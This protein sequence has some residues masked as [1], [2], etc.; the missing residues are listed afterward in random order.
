MNLAPFEIPETGDIHMAL[1]E[2]LATD[3][4]TAKTI[5]YLLIW[6]MQ[7]ALT[8][9]QARQII[10]CHRVAE[11][12]F[13]P[14]GAAKGAEW[15]WLTQDRP[16]TEDSAMGVIA[17]FLPFVHPDS[18]PEFFKFLDIPGT[19]VRAKTEAMTATPENFEEKIVAIEK[20]LRPLV[21]ILKAQGH[22]F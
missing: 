7:P 18:Q 19:I 10:R 2:E 4:S 13:Q 9:E 14:W 20:M 15:E 1:A 11:M 12:W 8:S 5:R 17:K 3:R 22:K 16:F 21:F 6:K